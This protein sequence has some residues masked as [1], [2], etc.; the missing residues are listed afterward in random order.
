MKATL[1]LALPIFTTIKIILRN[2]TFY[3]YI[4][5]FFFFLISFNCN[6]NLT[7]ELIFIIFLYSF[8]ISDYY[9]NI[10]YL[11]QTFL[12]YISSIFLFIYTEYFTR[13]RSTWKWR[14]LR[15]ISSETKRIHYARATREA[16][17]DW[18]PKIGLDEVNNL[19]HQEDFVW[20]ESSAGKGVAP[21]PIIATR[22][23]IPGKASVNPVSIILPLDS[24]SFDSEEG[25]R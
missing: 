1:I 13:K 8:L 10:S 25:I 14:G 18:N 5:I 12:A 19:N 22:L 3:L 7:K 11:I 21:D 17:G 16:R 24:S 20:F 6:F 23:A 9:I 4:R 15:R 2:W